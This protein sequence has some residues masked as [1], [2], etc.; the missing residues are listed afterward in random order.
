MCKIAFTGPT[1]AGDIGRCK[2]GSGRAVLNA[3]G[4]GFE[5]FLGG[6]RQ[7]VDPVAEVD[8]LD[9]HPNAH[10]GGDLNCDFVS[11]K[12]RLNAATSGIGAAFTT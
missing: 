6:P 4:I 9:R 10:V 2:P 8:R 12:V 3:V 1:A 11:Q 7:C 5:R